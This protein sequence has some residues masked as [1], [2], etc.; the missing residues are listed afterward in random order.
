MN[1][2]VLELAEQVDIIKRP[3]MFGMG[4]DYTISEHQLEK[5]A[6][7]IVKECASICDRLE[8]GYSKESGCQFKDDDN[9]LKGMGAGICCTEILEHFG[10]EE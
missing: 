1:N 2:K 9:A 10:V 4:W 3:N 6:E 7:L 8:D 5:F